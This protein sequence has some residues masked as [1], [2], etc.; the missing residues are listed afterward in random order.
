MTEKWAKDK[1][2]MKEKYKWRINIKIFCFTSHQINEN[3]DNNQIPCLPFPKI[4][5]MSEIV[6]LIN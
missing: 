3:K 1:K 2:L 6:I 5:R 4:I